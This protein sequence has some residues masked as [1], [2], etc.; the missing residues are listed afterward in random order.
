MSLKTGVLMVAAQ[1][2]DCG[3]F[4][5]PLGTRMGAPGSLIQPASTGLIWQRSLGQPYISR[6]RTRASKSSTKMKGGPEPPGDELPLPVLPDAVPLH[7]DE[8]HHLALR[9]VAELPVWAA[10]FP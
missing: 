10:S 9:H 2:R 3:S 6:P 7:G 4:I 8:E 5:H 1:T